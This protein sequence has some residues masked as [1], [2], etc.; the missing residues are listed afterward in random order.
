MDTRIEKLTKI[1]NDHH[2]IAQ[3]VSTP[4]EAKDI[5][6]E[7]IKDFKTVGM[8]GSTTL[9]RSGI[10]KMV[11]EDEQKVLYNS[12]YAARNNES[13]P[14]AMRN[15]LY[16]DVYITSSNAVTEDGKLVNIDGTGNRCAAMFYGPDTVIFVIGK[17][18]I[19]A[20][21]DSAILR[22]KQIA[23]PNNA[24]R[25]KKK[26][27]CALTGKCADCNGD[28]RMC[29]VTTIIERPTRGKTMHVILVDAEMGD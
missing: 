26:T 24:K 19:A 20:D 18:K 2:F 8:G 29:N 4:D 6:K 10:W 17:N 28:D 16:A 23:C 27:P 15:G 13:I 12:V 7:L 9:A 21:L 11:A 3:A 25:L 22:I 14:E 5:V 1:L